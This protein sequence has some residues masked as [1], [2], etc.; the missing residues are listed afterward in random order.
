M[1]NH[2]LGGSG[3]SIPIPRS[4]QGIRQELLKGVESGEYLLGTL[5]EPKLFKKMS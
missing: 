4:Y 1:C 5:I 3:V 2:N